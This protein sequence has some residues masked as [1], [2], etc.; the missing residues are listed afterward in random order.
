MVH[1]SVPRDVE[2]ASKASIWQTPL[3]RMLYGLGIFGSAHLEQWRPDSCLRGCEIPGLQTPTAH[4]LG[5]NN[6]GV[7]KTAVAKEYP[8]ALS[9]AIAM[10]VI[11]GLTTRWDNGIKGASYLWGTGIPGQGC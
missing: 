10:M 2:E 7:L 6:E 3:L 8:E 5:L 1:P 11:R 4:A 9:K